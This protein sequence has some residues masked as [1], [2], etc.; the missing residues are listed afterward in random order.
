[1][2]GSS[3]VVGAGPMGEWLAAHLRKKGEKV[4][5]YDRNLYRARKVAESL[6]CNYLPRLDGFNT[7]ASKA[8]IA[9]GSEHAGPLIIRLSSIL[10][11]DSAIIDISSVKTPVLH[12]IRGKIP[13]K[14]TVAL[15][16]PLFGPGAGKLSDK[17]VI[18]T[19]FRNTRREYG[20]VA[21]FFRPAHIITMSCREH[22]KLMAYC[23]SIPRLFTLSILRKWVVLD[24]V[25]LTTSQ[26]ALA[27]A[28]STML[29][30][31][32]KVFSE[33]VALNPYT[34]SALSDLVK[35]MLSL[36]KAGRRTIEKRVSESLKKI[37]GLKKYYNETY[38][39]LE[40]R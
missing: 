2:A 15:A 6:K 39:F 16:H 17:Y 23:M 30:D 32:P 20:V 28:A 40:N 24:A 34:G 27:M 31:N 5:I 9:T 37:P 19:P 25:S 8:F 36:S 29:I 18:F 4:S 11:S 12:Q 21:H 33:I 1:M 7:A 22:D 3:L 35:E 10:P 13:A 14:L 26:K 38:R